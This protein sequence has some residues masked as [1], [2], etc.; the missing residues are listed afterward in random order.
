MVHKFWPHNGTL[1]QYILDQFEPGYVGYGIDVGAS[2]GMSINTTFALELSHR[3]TII[4]VEANPG[5]APMLKE[6]RAF[7]EM[8][9]CSDKPGTGTFHIHEDNWE[10]FSSLAPKPQNDMYPIGIR[11]NTVEVPI[12]T[13]DE[14]LNKWEFPRLDLLC[15]DTEGTE[16]DVLKGANIAFWRP[17][18]IVT[19]CWEITG[20]IDPYL[21][22][23]GYKKTARSVDND[24][25]IL[26]ETT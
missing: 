19:E 11:W 22:A 25:F 20:P 12:C 3:W 26:K 16:L 1:A 15:V 13:V 23:L 2:D 6:R 24:V 8:C 4:S 9:A 21:E 18:V 5:F 10:S 17:K 7:V 14:L